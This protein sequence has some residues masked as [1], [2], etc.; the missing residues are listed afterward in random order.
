MN[1]K[2]G[3]VPMAETHTCRWV[4]FMHN[5][6]SQDILNNIPGQESNHES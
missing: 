1:R 6:M 5:L 3:L 4:S 2:R